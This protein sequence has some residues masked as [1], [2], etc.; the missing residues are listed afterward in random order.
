MLLNISLR[1]ISAPRSAMV[2]IGKKVVASVVVVVGTW[3]Q[4]SL[5]ILKRCTVFCNTVEA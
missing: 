5:G 2:G 4:V 3:G 1:Y